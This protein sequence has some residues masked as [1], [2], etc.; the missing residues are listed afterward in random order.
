MAAVAGLLALAI[1]ARAA[2]VDVLFTLPNFTADNVPALVDDTQQAE[3]VYQNDFLATETTTLGSREVSPEAEKKRDAIKGAVGL[4]VTL[5]QDLQFFT[6]PLSYRFTPNIKVGLALP[7]IR[8][9]GNDG[10]VLGIGDMS[11]SVG[12]RWGS[13]LKVLGITTAF[14]KTPT[15]DPEKQDA[16]EFLPTGSGSWDVALYQTFVKRF[17]RWRGDVTL[18]YRFNNEGDFQMD[19]SDVTLENG[20]VVNLIVGLD[21]ELPVTGLVA[22]VKVDVRWIGAP[23][24]TIDGVAQDVGNDLTV[25]DLL[26]GVHYFVAAGTGIHLGLRLPLNDTGNRDPALDLS[27][28]KTF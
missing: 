8:R 1:P 24:L 21:R 14:L 26:P 25:V 4:D 19:G 27:V 5:L 9:V 3:I 20:D 2:G 28:V 23:D 18:G 6:L 16:G 7:F 15:G 22:A 10:E 11:A 17:D 13:P 12:F